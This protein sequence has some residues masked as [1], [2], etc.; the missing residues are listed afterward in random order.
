MSSIEAAA[1]GDSIPDGCTVIEVRVSEL[2]QLFNSI[3]P[4]PFRERDLDP[5]VEEF[6][7]DWSREAPA[8]APLALLVRIDRPAHSAVDAGVVRDAIH[9]FFAQRAIAARR[10]LRRLFRV[11]RVSMTIGLVVLTLSIIA[12]QFVYRRTGGAGL[13]GIFHESLL[14]GGWV[15]MWRPLEIFLYDW[16]PIRA[17]AKLFDRLA[18]MPVRLSYT[19]AA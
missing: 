14:I 11:G 9:E 19:A 15:A 12:A 13:S 16:W 17:E 4:A 18:A 2:L 8:N 1:T 6:I 3:D 7:V 5:A 10:R